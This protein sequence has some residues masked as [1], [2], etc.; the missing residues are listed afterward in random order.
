MTVEEEALHEVFTNPSLKT[1][2]SVW[3]RVLCRESYSLV[4]YLLAVFISSYLNRA[5]DFYP[6]LLCLPFSFV[7]LNEVPYVCR[8]ICKYIA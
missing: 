2:Y 6:R 7:A 8:F 5:E 4:R 3:K 1:I